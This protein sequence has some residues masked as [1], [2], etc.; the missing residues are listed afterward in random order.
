MTVDDFSEEDIV[1]IVL[2]CAPG[3]DKFDPERP[4]SF[5]TV[6]SRLPE[7]P[8]Q[9]VKDRHTNLQGLLARHPDHFRIV[10]AENFCWRS[11]NVV[12]PDL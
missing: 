11:L 12:P 10:D 7:L 5:S 3:G 8:R 9:W 2:T 6:M 1:G 4:T